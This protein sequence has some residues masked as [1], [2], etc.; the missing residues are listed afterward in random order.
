MDVGDEVLRDVG[1]VAGDDGA[2]QQAAEAGRRVDGQHE[3]A[4]CDP[5][6]RRQW[7]GV[8]HLELGE[9]HPANLS[10][11]LR[12]PV[13]AANTPMGEGQT[14]SRT[15]ERRFWAAPM[16]SDGDEESSSTRPPNVV[17]ASTALDHVPT[18]TP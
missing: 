2:D 15:R 10:E 3:V 4:E 6:R 8:P 14:Y 5:P 12:R 18:D 7:P 13:G 11:C 1:D 16:M 9:E 17:A